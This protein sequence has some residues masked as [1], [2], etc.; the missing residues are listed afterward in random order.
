MDSRDLIM[1]FYTIIYDTSV[2]SNYE[3]NMKKIVTMAIHHWLMGFDT[4]SY[5]RV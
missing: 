3:P 4:I 1:G 5:D 2:I